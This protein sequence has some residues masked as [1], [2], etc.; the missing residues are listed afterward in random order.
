MMMIYAHLVYT[1][2]C[3]SVCRSC[4]I[5]WTLFRDFLRVFFYFFSFLYCDNWT[6]EF[7]PL[8]IN[9]CFVLRYM[10]SS[11]VNYYFA[12]FLKI[13]YY[14]HCFPSS[15]FNLLLS[16]ILSHLNDLIDNLKDMQSNAL[17]MSKIHKLNNELWVFVI[18]SLLQFLR[19]KSRK[20][21]K[22]LHG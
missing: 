6:S 14:L 12:D 7:V 16:L 17:K 8:S 5:K 2:F 18:I 4:L 9:N 22:A 10:W 11:F 3:L 15:D 19:V 13:I 20:I 1:L 21:T